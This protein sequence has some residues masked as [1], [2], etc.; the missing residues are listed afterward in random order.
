MKIQCPKCRQAVS[1]DQVNMA[2]DLAFCPQCNEGFKISESID[3]EVVNADV[4]RDPPKGAWYR[5]ERNSVVVGASTRSPI[6]FF[7]VPFM[8]VWS[9][10]SMFGLYG[11][12]F[13]KG[14][15]DLFMSLFGIPFL[16]G[17]IVLL[18]ASLMAVFGRIIVTIGRESSV[19]IG[20]G[21]IGWNRSFDWMGV[22]TVR[23]ELTRWQNNN[24]NQQQTVIVLDGEKCLK[25]GSGLNEE[26][27][28]FILNVLKYLV[29]Q[30]RGLF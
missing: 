6:A 27:R 19:F 28:R 17:S 18:S 1:P 13:L 22:K 29:S 30:K 21:P 23:E 24:G 15:F 25:F 7:L 9:G 20:M 3:Q 12:Q 11:T 26:R 16:L 14:E 8:L 2:T 10:G 4:L 5:K